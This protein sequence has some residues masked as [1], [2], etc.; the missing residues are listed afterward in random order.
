[1]YASWFSPILDFGFADQVANYKD[2]LFN[3]EFNEAIY[4]DAAAH[5]VNDGSLICVFVFYFYG[6]ITLIRCLI[7]CF[8]FDANVMA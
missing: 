4:N 2:I 1:M 5:E 3:L 7:M 6:V 8:V